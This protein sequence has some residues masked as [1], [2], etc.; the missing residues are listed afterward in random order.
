MG[1]IDYPCHNIT[2]SMLVKGQQT[3][4]IYIKQNLHHLIKWQKRGPDVV[5]ETNKTFFVAFSWMLHVLP[6]IKM[7]I[8]KIFLLISTNTQEDNSLLAIVHLELYSHKHHAEFRPSTLAAPE[9]LFNG[10]GENM[11]HPP[12]ESCR[13]FWALGTTSATL[14]KLIAKPLLHASHTYWIF[15]WNCDQSHFHSRKCIGNVVCKTEA[16]SSRL[17][18]VKPPWVRYQRWPKTGCHGDRHRK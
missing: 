5:G 6:S 8:E 17:L 1:V 16:I 13:V 12:A 3:F 7:V 14:W 4:M 2:E 11:G 10:G 15:E 18:W 9:Q